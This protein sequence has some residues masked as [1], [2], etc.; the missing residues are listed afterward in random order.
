MQ[1]A[2]SRHKGWSVVLLL[3]AGVA[4]YALLYGSAWLGLQI[5]GGLPLGNLLAWCGLL[6]L[7]AVVW[8]L[9]APGSR[10]WQAAR[11][12]WCLVLPWL[13]VSALLAG[14][15]ALKFTTANQW[16]FQLW[17]L[18]SAVSLCCGLLLLLMYLWQ[19]VSRSSARV[20]GDQQDLSAAGKPYSK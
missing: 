3:V 6:A 11:L 8:L 19:L 15:L 7:P 14:N 1:A 4:G 17:L 2:K 16:Q 12:L 20:A 18:Y 10:L 5:F 13:A 9:A